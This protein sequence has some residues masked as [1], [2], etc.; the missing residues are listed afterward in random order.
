LATFTRLL[1]NKMEE[2]KTFSI[3]PKNIKTNQTIISKEESK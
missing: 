2:K 1:S 3:A